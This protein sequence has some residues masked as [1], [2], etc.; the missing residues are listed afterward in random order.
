MHGKSM[1]WHSLFE[2]VL[3]RHGHKLPIAET[4]S[5]H[6]RLVAF[7]DMARELKAVPA[8]GSTRLLLTACNS[9][10]GAVSLNYHHC[11]E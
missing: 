6:F 11:G 3:L 7:S 4:T 9:R 5:G 8:Y 2:D 1:M 10:S